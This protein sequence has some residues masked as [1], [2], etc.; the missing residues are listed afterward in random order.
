MDRGPGEPCCLESGARARRT[1]ARSRAGPGSAR[2]WMMDMGRVMPWAG[3]QME[4]IDEHANLVSPSAGQ[5]YLIWSID[6]RGCS[7]SGLC[8]PE[9]HRSWGRGGSACPHRERG[10][11][12]LTDWPSTTDKPACGPNSRPHED[13][14]RLLMEMLSGCPLPGRT[15]SLI[16]IVESVDAISQRRRGGDDCFPGPDACASRLAGR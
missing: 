2:L 13:T 7:P 14:R 3:L 11:R 10:R 6:I 4:G 8:D 1:C 16:E 5:H 12:R 9:E 15:L